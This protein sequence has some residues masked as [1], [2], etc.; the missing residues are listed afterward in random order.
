MCRSKMVDWFSFGLFALC[1]LWMVPGVWAMGGEKVY[2]EEFTDPAAVA[3]GAGPGPGLD[4]TRVEA[5]ALVQITGSSG[6]A[7][8][9]FDDPA[10]HTF[11][12]ARVEVGGG[13]VRALPDSLWPSVVALWRFDGPGG[14]TGAAGEVLDSSGNGLAGSVAGDTVQAAGLLG[15]A[16][17]F[18]GNG[19]AVVLGQPPELDLDPASDFTVALWFRATG[20]AALLAKADSDFASRQLYL[21]VFDGRIWG[22]VGG[23][24]H[25]GT[26]SGAD[27]GAWHHGALVSFDDDGVRRFSL[28]LDGSPSGVFAAGSA[29]NSFDLLLGARRNSGNSGLAFPLNGAIDEAV[30][31][32]RALGGEEIAGL[33]NAGAGRVLAP[34]APEAAIFETAGDTLFNVSALDGFNA[35]PG[36]GHL[37][38]LGFQL[39]SDG[40]HWR[41][42]NGT[43][44][45]PAAAGEHN[46]AATVDANVSA[47]DTSAERIYVRSFLLSGPDT[48][49]ALDAVTLTYDRAPIFSAREV[50]G[51]VVAAHSFL[52]LRASVAAED[53]DH[54]VTFRVLEAD[55]TTPVDEGLLPGNTLGF[56]S[57]AV[58][59]GV[60]LGALPAGELYVEVTFANA[61]ADSASAA[62]DRLEVFYLDAAQAPD[63]AV[64]SSLPPMDP[65]PVDEILELGFEVA[66]LGDLEAPDATFDLALPGDLAPVGA[67]W[68]S[69][70][71]CS[72]VGGLHCTADTAVP[73]ASA[74]LWFHL[75]ARASSSVP[76]VNPLSVAAVTSATGD[77]D[78]SNDQ[79]SQRVTLGSPTLATLEVE[80][81]ADP[82][83]GTDF[84]FR[85]DGPATSELF[86]L[87]DAAPD[88]GDLVS[89]LHVSYLEP[90]EVTISET[91]VPGWQIESVSCTGV[92][93]QRWFETSMI[94]P[95]EL[96]FDPARVEVSGGQARLRP[97]PLAASV[98]A[99]WRFEESA[100][101]GAPGEVADASG[102]GLAGASL[103]D[104]APT[105]GGFL[106]SA[107]SF[108]GAGD[109]ISLGQ[110]AA[111]DLDPQS[112]FT[113][114][115]WFR[116]TGAGALVAKAEAGFGQRQL[117]LFVT[118]GS[119]WGAVGGNQNQGLS[120]G[121]DDGAWHHGVLVNEPVGAT[122]RYTLYLDGVADGSFDSG[123]VTNDV[124]LLLG[125]RRDTGNSGLA[126]GLD[127]ELDEVVFFDRALD[128]AEIASLYNGGAGRRVDAFPTGGVAVTRALGQSNASLVS[129]AGFQATAGEGSEGDLRFQL[130]R[131]GVDWWFWNGSA[132]ALAAADE[133]SSVAEVD[134][135]ISSFP[136]DGAQDQI[137]VRAFLLSDG[138][139]PVSVDHWRVGYH[140]QAA[141][142]GVSGPVARVDLDD[143]WSLRCVFQNGLDVVEPG[144][145]T[146][147][148]STSPPT[149]VDFVYSSPQLT[150]SPFPLDDASPDDG[151]AVSG[152]QLFEDLDPGTY[153]IQQTE[154]VAWPL[155]DVICNS[156]TVDS[157][158]RVP[159]DDPAAHGFDPSRIEVSGGEARLLAD[160]LAAALVGSWR[161]EETAWNGTAGEVLDSSGNG[162]SGT[163]TGN[164]SPTP[165]GRLGGGGDFGGAGAVVLGQPAA[166]DLDPATEEFTISA[167]FRAT[168]DGGLVG[169][170]EDGFA[171]RQYYLFVAGNRLQANVGGVQ[172]AE[173]STGA[174]DGSWHLGTLVNFDDGGVMR[175]RLYLDGVLQG[176]FA[177]GTSTNGAD[178]LIGAR[179]LPGNTGL[180]FPLNG[181]ID[182][183]SIFDQALS[184]A[185]IAGLYSEG[186]GRIVS[187]YP[188]DGAELVVGPLSDHTIE[189]F[190][191]FVETPGS[192]HQGD[193]AYQLSTDGA[194]WRF[195]NGSAWAVAGNGEHSP[196]A[197]VHLAIAA[198]DS[199]PGTLWIRAFLLSDGSQPAALDELEVT[200][201]GSGL[202]GL[203]LAGSQLT[204]D[205]QEGQDIVC[206][207]VNSLGQVDLSALTIEVEASPTDGTDFSFVGDLGSF[208]L[209]HA[210][211][212]DLD[213][214]Q[215]QLS[216]SSQIPGTYSI[217][218]QVPPGWVLD[219]ADCRRKQSEAARVVHHASA[220]DYD[221]DPAAVSFS[222]GRARLIE[223]PMFPDLLAYWR[224]EEP[225]WT[226]AAGEVADSSGQGHAGTVVGNAQPGPGPIGGAA[227]FGGVADAVSFG[228]PT[229]LDLDPGTA[230]FTVAAWFRATG[231]GAIVAKAD[232]VL[233]NRQF[234]LF[235]LENKLWAIVGGNLST[236]VT[237]GASDGGWHHAALVN[238]QAGAEMRHRLY[239]DGNLEG[240]FLSGSQTNLADILV[241]ARRVDGT[242]GLA[243]ALDGEVDEVTLLGRALDATE[244]DSLYGAGS[245]RVVTR[246]PAGA[247]PVTATTP[248][249][250]GLIDSFS[251]FLAFPT[252]GSTGSLEYQLSADGVPWSYFDGAA[253]VPVSGPE[254]R[255]DEATVDASIHL[256]DASAQRLYVRTFLISDGS[257]PVGSDAFEV[258]WTV[259]PVVQH[260][261]LGAS[262]S[263]EL[264]PG[265]DVICTFR[266]VEQGPLPTSLTVRVEA[267]PADGTDL[268]FRGPFTS[269]Y[270]Y[271]LDHAEPDDGDGVEQEI[272][273]GPIGPASY[274]VWADGASGFFLEGVTCAGAATPPTFMDE[275]SGGAWYL[276][277]ANGEDVVCTFRYSDGQPRLT[278]V[279]ETD[280]FGADHRWVATPEDGRELA[281]TSTGDWTGG[282]ASG[283]REVFWRTDLGFEQATMGQIDDLVDLSVSNK[284]RYLVFSSSA[285]LLGTNADANR[286][287][288]L[289]DTGSSVLTQL[290]FTSGCFN[291]APS[292]NERP[293]VAFL[294]SC[295]NLFPGSNPDHSFEIVVWEAGVFDGIENNCFPRNPKL[296]QGD[297]G[298]YVTFASF[299]DLTGENPDFAEQVFQWDRDNPGQPWRQVTDFASTEGLWAFDANGDG[300]RV[301]WITADF[302]TPTITQQ[303]DLWRRETGAVQQLV[304]PVTE[305]VP[306]AV[307]IDA[308]GEHLALALREA[309]GTRYTLQH[310]R[311]GPAGGGVTITDLLP[312][313]FTTTDSLEG[314]LDIG[315]TEELVRVYFITTDDLTGDNADLGEEIFSVTLE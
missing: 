172:S 3:A 59:A 228:A 155:D 153:R 117:Y 42:W 226:G 90:G 85:V 16:A 307:V 221:F 273:Y 227:S 58:S 272:V 280:T 255:N 238:Y 13:V 79:R 169:K 231:D 266:N 45:S 22:A 179:R 245:G 260:S 193:L 157:G 47:F 210:V 295:S 251:G 195:W 18:D 133:H 24:Q 148:Q 70:W 158:F 147:L 265:A 225:A 162:R 163:A 161:F 277:V 281:F 123:I 103:G 292:V 171:Q 143:H 39:S 301:A 248:L 48:P 114:S 106:G 28:Y 111:L 131:D 14:W 159:F 183:V 274:P 256:F 310:L 230:E 11:D 199:A 140:T 215:K 125:A 40:S 234:Y 263:V 127:G 271:R 138:N 150:P 137:F 259:D 220:D 10:A 175:H 296:S 139:Q 235:T 120:G 189:S 53:S 194:D 315:V 142:P 31:L 168:G 97:D 258:V 241:G 268:L 130:S 240:D 78:S 35:T 182:E 237:T 132:W 285:D 270:S 174:A 269:P 304:A 246:Y 81:Q 17:S 198:F 75:Q 186:S 149:G 202:G 218:E 50:I 7:G 41:F 26:L 278:V 36:P 116:T 275:S 38:N 93:G 104:A 54:G 306:D 264:E 206:T 166:L 297:G 43:A 222:G 177:S 305:R 233:A 205:L 91:P 82:R 105:A 136:F 239:L 1:L 62:V 68:P 286:E 242:T 27:D 152:L 247:W 32:D 34:V 192:G 56:D 261:V 211:P 89:S 219:S 191:G 72:L 200:Y 204:L 300:S 284:A 196:A 288:Y 184:A 5:G 46:D 178:V 51:P 308:S 33:Y 262:V 87:D 144:T 55:G 282:N 208:Q 135:A 312:A 49:A 83:D 243:F 250:D 76:Q 217:T 65:H 115:A 154:Q 216:T 224:F 267:Q 110:P 203:E 201:R 209:D 6:V 86:T 187:G 67:S 134:A 15:N 99:S 190:T 80:K 254:Q 37:G 12:P 4:E 167:W 146:L 236:G 309:G 253:W 287:I 212:D 302:G 290:T 102:N 23:E 2:L 173:S 77:A 151:D 113:V 207:F 100:W 29:T 176:T 64:L 303:V 124:D 112:E 74:S 128:S 69:G 185:D 223:D 21:F 63:L 165:A 311:I 213:G 289:W 229:A 52:E 121:A 84:P 107:A 73:A 88:D 66:N 25:S 44:W 94:Q 197:E 279:Q 126:F 181:Q 96:S 8:T 145:L 232:G 244:I 313:P 170:A 92:A 314:Q 180:G 98:L 291:A 20:N 156:N 57:A 61:L 101:T 95:S 188:T 214:P 9:E 108:D 276:H 160:P 298:R 129:L 109:A 119:L 293:A 122:W 118:G 71:S 294:T 30:I 252:P 19:D 299:C 249:Q 60:D 283:H 164:A 257:Q 141:I